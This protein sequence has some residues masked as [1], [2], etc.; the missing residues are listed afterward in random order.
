[1]L[2]HNV[3]SYFTSCVFYEKWETL[4]QI[5]T[6][7]LFRLCMGHSYCS[8]WILSDRGCQRNHLLPKTKGKG[9]RYTTSGTGGWCIVSMC[10]LRARAVV[11][12]LP[13]PRVRQ[14]LWSYTRREATKASMAA[15]RRVSSGEEDMRGETLMPSRYLA[16]LLRLSFSSATKSWSECS[17]WTASH[18]PME[19]QLA[20]PWCASAATSAERAAAAPASAS[21][22]AC[23]AALA[24]LAARRGAATLA[25]HSS[26]ALS[27]R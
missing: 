7:R 23:T 15:L 16:L 22:L 3:L 20:F 4:I 26:T 27:S 14:G 25:S 19:R 12:A 21:S 18:L 13:P 9:P 24:A 6:C 11:V 17:V 5:N 1:M 10:V 2:C 8:V